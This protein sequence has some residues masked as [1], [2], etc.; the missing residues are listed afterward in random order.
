MHI[1]MSVMGNTADMPKLSEWA[2]VQ[3]EQAHTFVNEDGEAEPV[4][5]FLAPHPQ[6][7]TIVQGIL[8]LGEFLS[9]TDRE[10]MHRKRNAMVVMIKS[11]LEATRAFALVMIT[12]GWMQITS[13][14]R[15]EAQREIEAAG[16]IEFLPDRSEVLT[17]LFETRTSHE[18]RI[19]QIDRDEEGK[20]SLGTEFPASLEVG[21][22]FS[23]FLHSTPSEGEAPN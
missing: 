18:T 20:A 11:I 2:Q 1:L 8:P 12:E 16:G 17:I 10:E 23:S 14:D 13:A 4:L 15:E 9:A 5:I 7:A 3:I 21:G 19:W 6:D 22:R